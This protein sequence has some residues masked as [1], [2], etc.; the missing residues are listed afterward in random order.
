M[1]NL[2][3]HP[4]WAGDFNCAGPCRRKR[5]TGSE[6]SK[7][8]LDK[9]RKEPAAQLRCQ[10]CVAAEAES[11]RQAAAAK[12]AARAA[13]DTADAEKHQCSTSTQQ[14]AASSFNRTQLSKG[15][16]K[17]RCQ[18]CVATSEQDEASAAIAAKQSKIA[19]AKLA[20]QRAEASGDVALKLAASMQHASLE[21]ERVTGLKPVVRGRGRRGGWSR[22]RGS[23]RGGKGSS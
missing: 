13:T 10:Q 18:G 20:M 11:E 22:G 2:A 14:L 6:F 3:G 7:K 12:Q 15:P 23:G 5:L 1:A 9:W 21:A 17:Q 8:S 16:G 19:D 4:Q